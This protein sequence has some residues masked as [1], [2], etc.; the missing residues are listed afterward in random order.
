L[1]RERPREAGARLAPVTV[2]PGADT[3][4]ARL[5]GWLEGV[6]QT[7]EGKWEALCPAHDDRNPSRSI[8]L[9]RWLR[10]GF[11]LGFVDRAPLLWRL[12]ALRCRWH[13]RRE[14]R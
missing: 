12:R 14:G 2:P 3:A 1:T 7:G 9:C 13:E 4:I 10:P 6:R 11:E 5:L 8:V